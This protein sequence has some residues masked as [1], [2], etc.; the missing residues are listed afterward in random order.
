MKKSYLFMAMAGMLAATS[1]GKNMYA[2]Y[3][4]VKDAEIQPFYCKDC[5]HY[6]D[7]KKFCK[8]AK[9]SIAANTKTNNCKH[10]G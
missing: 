1:S 10:F 8:V 2:D 7:G 6:K 4:D 5:K 3:N 9:H